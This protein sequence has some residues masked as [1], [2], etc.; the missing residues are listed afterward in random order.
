MSACSSGDRSPVGTLSA[1]KIAARVAGQ[2][3]YRH[4]SAAVRTLDPSMNQDVPGTT[5][6]QDL[7]EGLLRTDPAG[8]VVAGVAERWESSADGLTWTFH[9]RHNALWSNGDKVTARDFVYAWRRVVDPCGFTHG[10]GVGADCG[11]DADHGRQGVAC[12][13]GSHGAGRLHA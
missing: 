13:A 8:N 12:D 6:A 4:L 1:E 2:H 5:V 7:F 9:L 3:F 10:A 11:R